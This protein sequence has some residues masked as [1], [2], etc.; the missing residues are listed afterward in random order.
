M[1]Q[2]TVA[3]ADLDNLAA[4]IDNLE[5][6]WNN[7][8]GKG[9]FA[10]QKSATQQLHELKQQGQQPYE[11]FSL[12]S[13]L[14]TRADLP[15]LAAGFGSASAGVVGGYVQNFLK[16]MKDAQGKVFGMKLSTAS[17]LVAGYLIYKLGGSYN[18]YIGAFGGGV[19]IRAI[20]EAFEQLGFTLGK[21]TSGFNAPNGN[22]GTLPSTTNGGIVY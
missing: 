9:M 18:Q 21:F 19:L 10:E 1:S 13:L 20:G 5:A 3:K 8:K 2:V 6:T 15:M 14:P 4:R 17:Q 22:G 11:E 7:V 12:R 16:N